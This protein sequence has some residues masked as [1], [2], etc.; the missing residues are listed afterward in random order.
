MGE[1]LTWMAV[2]Q[3]QLLKIATAM[4]TRGVAIVCSN[5]GVQVRWHDNIIRNNITENDGTVSDSQAGLYIW[6]SSDDPKQFYNCKVYGNIVYNE[7]VA[8]ISFSDKSA[9]NG[10]DFYHNIFVG[11]DALI[12]GRDSLGKCRFTGNEWWSLESGFNIDGTKNL[13][14]WSAKTGKERKNGKLTGMNID[15]KFKSPDI[16]N[17]TDCNQMKTFTGFQFSKISVLKKRFGGDLA[18]TMPSNMIY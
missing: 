13:Q 16:S 18:Q 9:N 17:L 11:R 8:A 2:L 10:F 3:I 1:D 12:K 14:K 7:K 4:V 15:P 6:N 5:I